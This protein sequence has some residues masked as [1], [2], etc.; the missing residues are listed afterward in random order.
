M[1]IATRILLGASLFLATFATH[2][3]DPAR[4]RPKVRTVTA[5]VRLDRTH[6]DGEIAATLAVLRSAKQKFEARGYEVQTIRIVTQPLPELVA[7]LDH[8]AALQLLQRLDDAAAKEGFLPHVGPAMRRDGDDPAAM[9]LLGEALVTLPHVM[10]SSITAGDD[11]I[12][13]RVIAETAALLRH[14]ADQSPEGVGTFHFTAN[15]MV[16]TYGPFYPGA[17]HDGPGRHFSIGLQ[18]ANVVAIVFAGMHG[19]YD[20]TVAALTQALGEHARVAEAVGDEVAR[21][22]GWSYEGLDP[23]PAPMADVSIGGAI[24]AYTGARFGSSGTL[25]AASIITRAVKAVPV[26][27]VGYAGLMVPV[28]EDRVIARRFAEHAVTIDSLLAYSAVCGAGLDTVPVPG[29][30][31]EAQLA[32]IL[33][34]VAA[35]AVKWQKPLSARLQPVPGREAGQETRY[36][37]PYLTNTTLQPLP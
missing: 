15:A 16:K 33:G 22:S 29:S 10:G 8:A 4:D 35:L 27:Q 6:F 12:H 17:W 5:F 37:D 2:A 18:S 31:S 20:D 32:R 21:E 7:G 1:H 24:E 11:G 26:R 34:D 30:V 36:V 13:W 25:T 23:T 28:L 19:S 9:R 3:A 14:V